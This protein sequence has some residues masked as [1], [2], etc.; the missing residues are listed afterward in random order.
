MT[1][2]KLKEGGSAV[3]YKSLRELS[4]SKG[5][6]I[7][8]V[9]RERFCSEYAEKLDLQVAGY[10][11]F[12]VQCPEVT[13]RA[14]SILR[15]D[16]QI[17]DLTR[18]LPGAAA[19]QYA[20]KCLVDEIVITNNI[21]GVHSSRREIGDRLEE[22]GKQS[23]QKGKAGK[24]YGLVLKYSRL[25][26][27]EEVRLGTARELRALYDEIVLPE[28]V[29][30]NPKNRP[31]GELFRKDMTEIK[32]ASDRVK[33]RGAYPE[34]AII[35]GV[36]KALAFLNDNGVDPLYRMCIFH[37]LLEYIH[38]FYDGNGRLGRFI[39]SC[40]IAEN[41]ET[42][43]AYRISGTIKENIGKYYR[44]FDICNDK[45]NRGDLTP[46]LIMMLDM[47]EDS[48]AEL[49]SSLVEKLESWDYYERA[50]SSYPESG[51]GKR[52]RR[53]YSLLIQAALF[54]DVG[55]STGDLEGELGIS[56]ATMKKLLTPIE[57]AG[58]LRA[59]FVK[60]EKYYWLDLDKADTL[61]GM[62]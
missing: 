54:S 39:L 5:G 4:Y 14:L 53:L 41:L 25:M 50:I 11:A 17:C 16:K 30:D 3:S 48:A 1:I 47:L 32:T 27:G 55:I 59:Q 28:V 51:N 23:A 29:K 24:F 22:L 61:A 20:R 26:G 42:L 49:K 6:D 7:E 15:L 2:K 12:F 31:D 44:A 8:A 43:L 18:S 57:N 37:Y 21:E 19:L 52:M 34:S 58:L 40:G 56:F 10:Q 33:H 60:R 35:D 36:E 9:Y 45:R 38:P 46:F 62:R 13:A